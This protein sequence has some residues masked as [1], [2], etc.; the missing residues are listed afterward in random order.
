MLNIMT[1]HDL[2][3]FAVPE[4]SCLKPGVDLRTAKITPVEDMM[5]LKMVPWP[6]AALTN[7]GL[8]KLR[9]VLI[10][11]HG[12]LHNHPSNR[13]KRSKIS[14]KRLNPPR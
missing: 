11:A 8:E 9:F 5:I 1:G 4:E 10:Q 6:G 3:A 2:A 13:Y 7:Q 14:I 12:G